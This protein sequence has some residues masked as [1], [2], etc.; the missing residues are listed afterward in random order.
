MIPLSG[1]S[2]SDS[3]QR[4][5]QPCPPAAKKFFS[6]T[7]KAALRIRPSVGPSVIV[8]PRPLAALSRRKRPNRSSTG[9]RFRRRGALVISTV[10]LDGLLQGTE[11]FNEFPAI[12]DDR[13]RV[14]RQ[15]EG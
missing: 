13:R 14:S 9:S 2:W 1:S 4:S 5:T 12:V 6:W 3:A 11:F 15:N 7:P 10:G 8:T